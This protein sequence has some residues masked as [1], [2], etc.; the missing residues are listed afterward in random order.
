MFRQ[1]PIYQWNL[2][3]N[4]NSDGFSY[5]GLTEKTFKDRFYKHD[6]SFKYES[7]ANSTELSEHFWEMKTQGIKKPM[8]NWSVIDHPKPYKNGSK[9]YNLCL[10]E[11][12]HILVSRVN[13]INNRS[14]LQSVTKIMGKTAIWSISCFFPLPPL[15]NVEKQ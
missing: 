14:E 9:R 2:K 13:L 8:I 12:Y 1:G 10:T 11:K 6:K 5:N 7:K 15:N 3:E 4:T